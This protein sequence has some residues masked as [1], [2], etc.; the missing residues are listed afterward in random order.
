MNRALRYE[1][2]L[3]Y[4]IPVM[5]DQELLSIFA[6]SNL[7]NDNPNLGVGADFKLGEYFSSGY[8]STIKAGDETDHSG[9]IRYQRG[10]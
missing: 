6:R 4:G 7:Q 3:K 8:E 5:Q 10:F 9:Y 2:E 1:L